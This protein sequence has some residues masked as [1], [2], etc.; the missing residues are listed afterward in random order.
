MCGLL[1]IHYL[2]LKLFAVH[3]W[4]P[5]AIGDWATWC[6]AV[7]TL[8]TLFM[9]IRLA[10]SEQ[11]RRERG[12]SALA[13][14]SAAGLEVELEECI[15]CIKTGLPLFNAYCEGGPA[16]LLDAAPRCILDT[17]PLE[18]KSAVNLVTCDPMLAA[19]Y[20]RV[21]S[22]FTAIQAGF[23]KVANSGSTL[24]WNTIMADQ[25]YAL[26]TVLADLERCMMG[27]KAIQSRK[28]H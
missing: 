14:V 26:Q 16:K 19:E 22:R 18:P 1:I 7:G 9:T 17:R 8:A 15:S 11:R 25:A 10:T 12:E 28:I 2:V 13:I 3:R 4:T 20:A 21:S 6:G 23:R 5:P 27:C 24:G